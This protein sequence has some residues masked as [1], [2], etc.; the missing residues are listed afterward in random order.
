MTIASEYANFRTQS[1]FPACWQEVASRIALV[2]TQSIRGNP[3]AEHAGG[4][5][6]VVSSQD[7]VENQRT[8]LLSGMKGNFHVPFW[9]EN[10]RVIALFLIC[11]N[12]T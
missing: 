7:N 5:A 10:G 2:A 1:N 8:Q 12:R 3:T 11:S 9:D 6:C 4:N